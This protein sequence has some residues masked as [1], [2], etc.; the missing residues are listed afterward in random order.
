MKKIKPFQLITAVSFVSLLTGLFFTLAP[1]F[2]FD[3]ATY[4]SDL[5]QIIRSFSPNVFFSVF[6]SELW[7]YRAD[8]MVYSVSYFCLLFYSI[9]L[10]AFV[11][12]VARGFKE[13]RILT[14]CLSIVMVSSSLS[15][16]LPVF[17]FI[18]YGDKMN[19][20]IILRI[21]LGMIVQGSWALILLYTIKLL[22]RHLELDTNKYE[23]DGVVT[24][25]FE[26]SSRWQRF[27]HLI[28]DRLFCILIF[29]PVLY[30]F[31]NAKYDFESE[32]FMVLFSFL[33]CY[34]IYFPFFEGLLGA[35]PA[36]IL[37]GTRVTDEYGN[38]PKFG[39]VMIRTL[40]RLVPFEPFSF[41]GG[42]GW[43]DGW[44]NTYVLREKTEGFSNK[45]YILLL[46]LVLVLAFFIPYSF[47]KWDEHVSYLK[48][49]SSY[50]W[51]MEDW[52]SRLKYL[53]S[54]DLL[55]LEAINEYS[56]DVYYLKV[57]EVKPDAI[58]F[59]KLFLKYDDRVREPK[60]V[61]QYYLYHKEALER[62]TVSRSQLEKIFTVGFDEYRKGN[63]IELFGNGKTYQL[64]ELYTIEGPDLR[65]GNGASYSNLT[66]VLGLTNHGDNAEVIELKSG[67]K[68]VQWTFEKTDY[69]EQYSNTSKISLIAKPYNYDSKYEVKMTLKHTSGRIY[70]Y[71]ITG[72]NFDYNMKRL[73]E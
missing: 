22:R 3:S 68:D 16:I 20:G 43:H 65:G 10:L 17:S 39:S 41:L 47:N 32:R 8:D 57:E 49:K 13:T 19:T 38:K 62:I 52:H 46:P 33:L 58:T 59:T 23:T 67:D 40:S 28:I 5:Y 73:Y 54:N 21:L 14:F 27:G 70:H 36:K 45:K 12:F 9:F 61:K 48:Q 34:L 42:R 69:P 30:Y 60:E 31:L 4:N 71:L 72:R 37:T 51:K 29:S 24:V 63:G 44:S 50:D 11:L 35:T 1:A 18:E 64:K 7:V 56:L 53:S 55:Q 66:L 15:A 25:S 2:Q 26:E 6:S